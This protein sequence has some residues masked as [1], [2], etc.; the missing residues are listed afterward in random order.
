[1]SL[2]DK[3]NNA[4]EVA[5]FLNDTMLYIAGYQDWSTA[6]DKYPL[7]R[8]EE[9]DHERSISYW[10]DL[11][12]TRDPVIVRL[13]M[14]DNLWEAYR[15]CDRQVISEEQFNVITGIT[16]AIEAGSRKLPFAADEVSQ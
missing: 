2:Y 11:A 8:A 13:Q 1:M 3:L 4:I 12:V 9:L 5:D 15:G 6:F 14:R 16:S 10:Q 7:D